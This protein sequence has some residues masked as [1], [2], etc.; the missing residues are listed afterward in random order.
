[1]R[2][3]GEKRQGDAKDQKD[4]RR[5]DGALQPG[6]G[7]KH[8]YSRYTHSGEQEGDDQR[9]RNG[10]DFTAHSGLDRSEDQPY[11]KSFSTA[12]RAAPERFLR[13][14]PPDVVWH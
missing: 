5:I 10:R 11:R 2:P 14:M 13:G 4:A 1:M 3:D 8:E 6:N 9:N 12:S 7:H